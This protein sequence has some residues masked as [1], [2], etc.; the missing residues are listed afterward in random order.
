MRSC[1]SGWS[2]RV[3]V[4]CRGF[5]VESSRQ[6]IHFSRRLR[7]PPTPRKDKYPRRGTQVREYLLTQAPRARSPTHPHVPLANNKV[8]RTCSLLPPFSS[9]LWVSATKTHGP[10]RLPPS[11][12]ERNTRSIRVVVFFTCTRTQ[13]RLAAYLRDPPSKTPLYL[14]DHE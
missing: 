4:V 14:K 8:T 3:G 7:E 10:W 11:S 12:S 1:R 9:R 2:G 6:P 5:G 13:E